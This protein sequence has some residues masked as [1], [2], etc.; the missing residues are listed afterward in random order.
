A[1]HPA[2][3]RRFLDR[4]DRARARALLDRRADAAVPRAQQAAG[5]VRHGRDAGDDRRGAALN[6][7]AAPLAIRAAPRAT[8]AAL[9]EH[10]RGCSACARFRDEMRALDGEIRIALERAPETTARPGQRGAPVWQR[11]AFAASIALATFAVLGVWVLRPTD[12]L[13]HDV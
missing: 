10:V 11:W 7:A 6:R 12:T 13:A 8:A 2:G 3:P 1:A 9:E 5:A 4:G